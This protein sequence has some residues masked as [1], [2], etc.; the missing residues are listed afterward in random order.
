MDWKSALGALNEIEVPAAPAE[1]PAEAT[2]APASKKREKLSIFMEKKG[3]AGKV[4][5]IITGF[6][7]SDEEVEE[8]ARTLKK[9]IGVGG[10]A[11]GG[12]ILLQG[13]WRDKA[14]EVLRSLNFK[15]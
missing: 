11:R 4:A 1:T 8:V 12:E 9:R 2:S 14:A 13:D 6:T 5:T 10:S 15:I 7:G 3:R